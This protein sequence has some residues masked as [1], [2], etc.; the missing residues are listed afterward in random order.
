MKG[1]HP[2]PELPPKEAAIVLMLFRLMRE[3]RDVMDPHEEMDFI[4]SECLNSIY[5]FLKSPSINDVMLG[6]G[7]GGGNKECDIIHLAKKKHKHTSTS[8]CF[9]T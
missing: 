7:E 9:V 8:I 4:R 6:K 1:E 3:M 5:L 2:P